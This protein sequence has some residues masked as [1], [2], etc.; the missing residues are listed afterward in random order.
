MLDV[1]RKNP[2]NTMRVI[3]L[4]I[5]FILLCSCKQQP[6]NKM[7]S[8]LIDYDKELT[9]KDFSGVVLIARNDSI[10]FNKAYG[11]KN[12]RENGIN[13]LNTVFDICSLT[14]QF[15]GAGIMKLLMQNKISLNDNIL[16]YFDDVPVDKKDITI[17]H[18]L[19]HSSGLIDIVGNDYD[20]ITEEEFLNKVFSTKLVS[21]IGKEHHYSNV[22]YSLLALIIEKASG[23][24][25]ENFL[26][27]EIFKPSKMNHTGYIIP[28]WNNNNIANGFLNG[29]ETKK[30]NEENWNE[31]G[32]YLNLKGNGGIMSRAGDLLLWSKAIRDNK[33][34]DEESTSK[35]LYP[36]ILE[37]SDGSSY[38]GYGWVIE[39]NDLEEK[40]VWHNG[41]SETFASD[42]WI[43]PKKGIT[44]I[45][46]SNKSDEYVY[47][48]TNELS[49]ILLSK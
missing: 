40:L 14:K 7:K 10:I 20:T 18:L 28:N 26:N 30:P 37:Y 2:L 47:S 1:I 19:T 3:Y 29:K 17:H 5:T 43:Y 9:E 21:Q 42:M 38:Y 35:Y 49:E 27:S 44:L 8:E 46:L 25:F 41:G 13:D 32:P 11:I 24:N 36:H 39:N 45:V 22:G 4:L 6:V 31:Q 34:L 33:I 15:T 16:K 12:N 48:I 23:M